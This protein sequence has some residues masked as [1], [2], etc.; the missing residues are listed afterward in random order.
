MN[1][2]T[3]LLSI[4]SK[5]VLVFMLLISISKEKIEDEM[6]SKLRVQAYSFAFMTGVI[7]ALYMPIIDFL[8]DSVVEMQ[9]SD[10]S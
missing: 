6:I 9:A 3:V 1:E 10:Y 7:Y 5:L 4:S 2:A 8:V